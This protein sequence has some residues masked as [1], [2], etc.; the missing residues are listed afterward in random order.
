MFCH[1]WSY[2]IKVDWFRKW[3]N[4]TG[5][6]TDAGKRKRGVLWNQNFQAYATSTLLKYFMWVKQPYSVVLYPNICL[7][8]LKMNDKIAKICSKWN[9]NLY[10]KTRAFF[11][12]NRPLSVSTLPSQIFSIYL[13][14][15]KKNLM[16]CILKRRTR[17]RTFLYMPK[18]VFS[19]VQDAFQNRAETMLLF[20]F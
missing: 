2:R 17:I 20:N 4:P 11:K 15:I 6:K 10:S 13:E 16:W 9:A 8:I 1:V 5:G 3:S 19:L 7:K 12:R 18:I 14:K